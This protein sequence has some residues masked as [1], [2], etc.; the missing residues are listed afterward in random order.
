MMPRRLCS[1]NS[2]LALFGKMYTRKRY[3]NNSSPK[4]NGSAPQMLL[5]VVQYTQVLHGRGL[6]LF[7]SRPNCSLLL[8]VLWLNCFRTNGLVCFFPALRE[9]PLSIRE[10]VSVTE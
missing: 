3:L 10:M 9:K 7:L 2:L 4:V 6:Q 8:K 1:T 5:P